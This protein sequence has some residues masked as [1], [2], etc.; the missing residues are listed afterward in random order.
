MTDGPK[1][2]MILGM[3]FADY[4]NIDAVNAST[5]LTHWGVTPA[6]ARYVQ[7][8][9]DDDT[10]AKVTGS[11]AH[12]VILEPSVFEDHFVTQPTA[13][14]FGFGDFRTK[15]AKEARDAW[16]EEHKDS[17]TINEGEYK[18]AIGMR[19]AT[20]SDEFLSSLLTSSGKNELTLLWTDEPTGLKCKALV[21][22]ITTYRGYPTLIDIKTTRALDDYF[23]QK[24][25]AMY[26]YHI[27]V[28][29]Y[30]DALQL[31]F[32]DKK[33]IRVFLLWVLNRPPYIGRVTEVEE[34]GLR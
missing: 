30:M 10:T 28:A 6:E 23:L 19:D 12:A 4:V 5:L 14:Q 11:A 24:S 9:G 8:H 21:D 34:D 32:A 25:M 7:L 1:V 20:K 31:R 26:H 33:E 17:V 27:R 29:W 18:A 15:K 2:K 3:S 22:R 13:A 16:L